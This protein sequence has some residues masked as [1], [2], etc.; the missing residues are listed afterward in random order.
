MCAHRA[1]DSSRGRRSLSFRTT[2]PRSLTTVCGGAPDALA[3]RST[4][5]IKLVAWAAAFAN[6]QGRPKA[7]QS[8][9]T[10][11]R[12]APPTRAMRSLQLESA[13]TRARRPDGARSLPCSTRQRNCAW[14]LQG[15]PF[16]DS[17]VLVAGPAMHSVA[18][19]CGGSVRMAQQRLRVTCANPHNDT[20]PCTEQRQ[21]GVPQPASHA[22]RAAERTHHPHRAAGIDGRK[23]PITG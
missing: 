2:T 17:V 19:R 6:R 21:V 14:I 9:A 8:K 23:A 10:P 16:E 13:R 4:P 5:H 12:D 7:S 20:A 3:H 15:G 22:D 11:S 1:R 18:L